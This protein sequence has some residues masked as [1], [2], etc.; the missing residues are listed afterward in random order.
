MVSLQESVMLYNEERLQKDDEL[1]ARRQAASKFRRARNQALR[2]KFWNRLAGRDRRLRDLNEVLGGAAVRK[3]SFEGVRS[4]PIENI[5]GSEG[6]NLDFDAAFRPLSS[7]NEERWLSVAAALSQGA[8]LPPVELIRLGDTY[9]VRDGHHRI[10]VAWTL[11]QKEI[12]AEV[13][14]WQI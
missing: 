10:S 13:T 2:S 7:H 3:S 12:D 8:S 14:A 6:R 1:S 9:F 4:V 11:G 5:R